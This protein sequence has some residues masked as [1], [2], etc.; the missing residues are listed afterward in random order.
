M[1][2]NI[3]YAG[4]ALLLLIALIYFLSNGKGETSTVG[5]SN[6]DSIATDII[7]MTGIDTASSDQTK[8]AGTD[9]VV[10]PKGIDKAKVV[11]DIKELVAESDNKGKTCETMYTEYEALINKLVKDKNNKNLL[12]ELETWSNDIIF[13][14]CKKRDILFSEKVDALSDK[15]IN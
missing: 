3:I 9:V 6:A 13:Q 5:I 2:K 7:S 14:Q 12:E 4:G 10:I 11:E 1:N 8:V 15:L